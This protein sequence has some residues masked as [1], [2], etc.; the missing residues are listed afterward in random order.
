MAL[1]CM[2]SFYSY[3]ETF[4]KTLLSLTRY[5]EEAK[6]NPAIDKEELIAGVEKRASLLV[7][8]LVATPTCTAFCIYRE[9]DERT[10]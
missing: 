3:P 7:G 4:L 8:K 5:V 6:T 1:Q 2:T 9:K 10:F